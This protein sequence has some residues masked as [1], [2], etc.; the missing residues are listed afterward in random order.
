MPH[1]QQS[2]I[3]PSVCSLLSVVSQTGCS[4]LLDYPNRPTA[5]GCSTARNHY[6]AVLLLWQVDFNI[7][8]TLVSRLIIFLHWQ[9]WSPWF[10][11]RYKKKKKSVCFF[12]NLIALSCNRK[13]ISVV[14]GP[15]I[16]PVFFCVASLGSG[17][18]QQLYPC[19]VNIFKTRF[20]ILADRLA[21]RIIRS[22][23][24]RRKIKRE[25]VWVA[26]LI[27]GHLAG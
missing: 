19:V 3:Q 6:V 18:S 24:S 16:Y 4:I 8:F 15:E 17:L 2:K 25:K 1:R 21:I 20:V 9:N 13:C 12:L 23:N 5:L 22:M 11:N 14:K 26:L 7:V 10:I 27:N